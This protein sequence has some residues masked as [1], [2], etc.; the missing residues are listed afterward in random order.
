MPDDTDL[1][2]YAQAVAIMGKM[3][4]AAFEAWDALD[5]PGAEAPHTVKAM[6]AAFADHLFAVMPEAKGH[7]SLLRHIGFNQKAITKTSSPMI[8]PPLRRRLS[9][10]PRAVPTS[11][12][13]SLALK[14]CC[15]SSSLKRACRYTVITITAKQCG[16]LI[17]RYTP[18]SGGEAA[19]LTTGWN[20]LALC[21]AP[22]PHCSSPV[23]WRRTPASTY[24]KV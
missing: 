10:G 6:M 19:G 16:K 11:Q 7:S 2:R 14:I 3:R 4:T 24:I 1:K 13:K 9:D 22:R 17:R 15:T 12:S 21:S 23:I 20:L 18:R 8:C 5:T